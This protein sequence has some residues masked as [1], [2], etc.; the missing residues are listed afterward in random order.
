MVQSVIN[1]SSSSA[2]KQGVLIMCRSGN[3]LGALANILNKSSV[4][5]LTAQTPDDAW[6]IVRKGLVG[7]IVQDVTNV[8]HDAFVFFRA[9]R[10]S[11]NTFTIPF[12]FLTAENFIPPKYEGVW[13]ETVRDHWLALPCPAQQFMS[14]VRNLLSSSQPAAQNQQ[15]IK[16]TGSAVYNASTMKPVRMAAAESAPVQTA[17]L[18][19]K[20]GTLQLSQIL[21]LIEPLKLTGCLKLFDGVRTGCAYFVEGKVHHAELNEIIGSEALFLLFHLNNGSFQFEVAPPTNLRTVEGNT[22]SLLL[23]GMRKMDEAKAIVSAI[24]E[25]Q[26]T[27]AYASI[28]MQEE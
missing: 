8:S 22:M 28:A 5:V 12:L 9:C 25:R 1:N 18:S 17:L 27:G 26:N 10:S 16:R 4:T 7:C 2:A 13:P 21:G 14:S 24:K 20:L 23:E 3:T 11:R 19:G 6:E 15:S